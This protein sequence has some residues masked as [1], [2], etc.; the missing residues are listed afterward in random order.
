MLATAGS[1]RSIATAASSSWRT[2]VRRG[3][4]SPGVTACRC[5]S[6]ARRSPSDRAILA[7]SSSRRTPGSRWPAR[8]GSA[9]RR[10]TGARAPPAHR[11]G[12]AALSMRGPGLAAPSR[13]WPAPGGTARGAAQIWARS[14]SARNSKSGHRCSDRRSTCSV[15][16][17]AVSVSCRSSRRAAAS[18]DLAESV[19]SPSGRTAAVSTPA[20]QLVFSVHGKAERPD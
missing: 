15:R 8:P 10:E 12:P 19:A 5:C 16:C 1:S 11:P 18:A 6:A 2:S 4:R 9:G 7:S 14:S 3:V 13:C 17:S 20:P